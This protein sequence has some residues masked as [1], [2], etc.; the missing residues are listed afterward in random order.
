MTALDT[1]RADRA[2]YAAKLVAM[3]DS[4]L[5]EEVKDRVWLSGYATNNP[6]W[7]CDA[8]HDEARRR[9]KPWLYQRGWNDAY[10]SA[11]HEPSESDIEAAKAP[12][13]RAIKNMEK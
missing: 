10:R 12:A 11:G 6:R 2:E 5:V 8:T 7:Q 4:E 9:Q 3:T 1:L 13:A